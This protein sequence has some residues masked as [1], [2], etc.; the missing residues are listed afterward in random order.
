MPEPADYAKPSPVTP[1]RYLRGWEFQIVCSR[2]RH[3]GTLTTAELAK[4][5]GSD[6]RVHEVVTR[7]RCSGYCSGGQCRGQRPTTHWRPFTP[8]PGR[9]ARCG[10]ETAAPRANVVAI[11]GSAEIAG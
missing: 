11:S 1:M 2:C 7:V 4:R 6:L 10:C 8:R 5:H 9:A 3:L